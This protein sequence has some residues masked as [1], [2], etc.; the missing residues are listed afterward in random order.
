MERVSPEDLT[1]LATDTGP[2]PMQVG[3]ILLLDAAAGFDVD[4]AVH[5]MAERIRS[6]P[7][8]RQRLVRAPL[9][10]GRPVWVDDGDFEIARHVEVVACPAPGDE[11]ALLAV[12]ADR[13][14][15]RLPVGQP[16][17]SAT[18]VTGIVGGRVA[19]VVVFHHVLADGL[20]GLAVL[21]QLVD[22]APGTGVVPFP[23]PAPSTG[24]LALDA[25]QARARALT[26]LPDG[27]AH[28]RVAIAELRA[29]G[30][31]RPARSSL[32]RPTGPRRRFTIVRT[33][34]EPVVRAAHARGA[35]VNDVVLTAVGGA[36]HRLLAAR[37]E[38]AERFV[39][40]VPVSARRSA[41]V[42]DLGNQVGV[43]PIE[44]PGVGPPSDRLA[45]VARATGAAKEMPRGASAALLGPVFRL[46]ARLGIFHWYIDRQRL[47]NT[48]VTNLRGPDARLTFL[49]APIV[50]VLPVALVTGNVTV[51]FAVM[52]YAGSLVVTVI[53]DPDACPD[54]AVLGELLAGELHALVS[55]RDR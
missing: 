23:R 50:D 34:L 6:I 44:V 48:F 27:V 41:G 10:C 54:V 20:G 7:R 53:A 16:L 47:V 40:S 32:N 21:A 5:A 1:S 37:G 13:M 24:S 15:A 26:R 39:V 43:V 52:S 11:T 49:D 36:L 46:L 22:G 18:F 33:G 45:A 31:A 42:A 14:T 4:R 25:W 29:S 51:S 9:G 38:Q 19:L 17:W 55:A 30:P 12:A 2:A 35:T 8:L 28:V 3:A